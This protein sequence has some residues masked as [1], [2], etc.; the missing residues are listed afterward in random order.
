MADQSLVPGGQISC[1]ARFKDAGLTTGFTGLEPGYRATLAEC[2]TRHVLMATSQNPRPVI[3]DTR[4]AKCKILLSLSPH[5]LFNDNTLLRIPM[6][7]VQFKLPL[8]TTPNK[9]AVWH[10]SISGVQPLTILLDLT[11]V[12]GDRQERCCRQRYTGIL[13]QKSV[14]AI[15]SV[16]LSA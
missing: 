6:E 7:K 13:L 10:G 15:P 3:G 5:P 8:M 4:P 9:R 12:S 2:D 16:R 1:R 11:S 14:A